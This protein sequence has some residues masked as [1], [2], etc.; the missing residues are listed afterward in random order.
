V[1]DRGENG[2]VGAIRVRAMCRRLW[3]RGGVM[4]DGGIVVGCRR[5]TDQGT[6]VA[7][8]W[9]G[10]QRGGSARWRMDGDGR[11]D[12]GGGHW[13]GGDVVLSVL[14]LV[15]L[16]LLRSSGNGL[17]DSATGTSQPKS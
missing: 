6:I 11:W 9:L 16:L 14:L 7:D 2:D 3:F 4:V 1:T 5:F 8:W 13:S 12:R 10:V 15:L 17:R